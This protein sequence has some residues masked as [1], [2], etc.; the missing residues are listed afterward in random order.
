MLFKVY[1]KD[2]QGHNLTFNILLINITIFNRVFAF[3]IQG[4][5][6]NTRS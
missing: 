4:L 2:I 6:G 5:K 1:N 3:C